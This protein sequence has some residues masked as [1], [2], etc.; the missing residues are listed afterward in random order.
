MKIH[1]DLSQPTLKINIKNKTFQ[2]NAFCP[3]SK[4][5]IVFR[6]KNKRWTKRKLMKN[7]PNCPKFTWGCDDSPDFMKSLY[8]KSISSLFLELSLLNVSSVSIEMVCDDPSAS[9]LIGF[10]HTNFRDSWG[11]FV[12]RTWPW[13]S[14]SSI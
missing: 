12:A 8:Q 5:F 4:V 10:K 14:R 6:W 13:K 7:Y 11:R 9:I 3:N 2:T 1:R